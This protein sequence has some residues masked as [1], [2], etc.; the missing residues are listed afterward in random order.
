MQFFAILRENPIF[1]ANFGLR[2]PLGSKLRWLTVQAVVKWTELLL[3]PGRFFPLNNNGLT[4]ILDPPLIILNEFQLKTCRKRPKLWTRSFW[5]RR[6]SFSHRKVTDKFYKFIVHTIKPP[7]N[8]H[9]YQQDLGFRFEHFWWWPEFWEQ[10]KLVQ[11]WRLTQSRTKTENS[12]GQRGVRMG[13]AKQHEFWLVK[14]LRVSILLSQHWCYP[15]GFC[16]AGLL[17]NNHTY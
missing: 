17:K 7:R 13:L 14:T 2:A 12:L 8:F 16:Q 9:I 6:H 3:P 15:L 5:S 10:F 1:W 11:G 4:K